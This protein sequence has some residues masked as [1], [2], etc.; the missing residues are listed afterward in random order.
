MGDQSGW[1]NSGKI[2]GFDDGFDVSRG[3]GRGGNMAREA[4]HQ[5]HHGKSS[6]FLRLPSLFTLRFPKPNQGLKSE[7]EIEPYWLQEDPS[8][9]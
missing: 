6:C 9:I 5:L 3:L 4:W 2:H 7:K 8:E 1:F